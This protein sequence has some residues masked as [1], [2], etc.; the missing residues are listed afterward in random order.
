LLQRMQYTSA[1]N[2]FRCRPD[3]HDC[4]GRPRFL[5]TGVAKSAV[6]IGDWFTLLPNR[7]CRAELA[8]SFKVL[9]E[10]R[11]QSLKNLSAFQL[12]LFRNGSDK[13]RRS[14]VRRALLNASRKLALVQNVFSAAQACSFRIPPDITDAVREMLLI[15]NQP[16]E[17]VPLP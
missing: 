11:F 5:A 6:K 17:I 2:S 4:V 13:E 9:V 16:I 8:E 14:L 12:H 1:A 15:A 10:Q 7:N 3:E